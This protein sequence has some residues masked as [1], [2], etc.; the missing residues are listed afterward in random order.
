ME[1]AQALTD[2]PA[3]DQIGSEAL[4][5]L[6]L[7]Q[8]CLGE[9]G[10]TMAAIANAPPSPGLR[11]PVRSKHGERRRPLDEGAARRVR[12]QRRI[13]VAPRAWQIADNGEKTGGIQ[14]AERCGSGVD[15]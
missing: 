13:H 1:Q 15:D 4:E 11:S 7:A 12:P 5:G 2:R 8:W 9:G 3:P 14:L 10:A 6:S